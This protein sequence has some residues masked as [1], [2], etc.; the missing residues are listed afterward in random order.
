MEDP[1]KKQRLNILLKQ[2]TKKE[3]YALAKRLGLSYSA[4]GEM[5]L[6]LGLTAF[7]MASNPDNTKAFE[8]VMKNYDK[9]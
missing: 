5:L 4:T 3:V 8:Q 9:L 1:L 6:T 7:N 2:D